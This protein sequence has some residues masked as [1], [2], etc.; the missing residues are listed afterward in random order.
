MNDRTQPDHA[1]IP[2]AEWQAQERALRAERLGLST[3][4]DDASV[5]AY[6]A[7]ARALRQPLPDPLPDDFA[8]H[9]AGMVQRSRAVSVDERVL[10][11][12]V[13]GLLFALGASVLILLGLD[14]GHWWQSLITALPTWALT[15]PWLLSLAACATLTGLFGLWPRQDRS[16]PYLSERF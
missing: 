1:D 14:G 5:H 12:L 13:R 15:N 11:W 8:Q 6:R 2:D 16:V 4:A 7:V 3:H 9:M 10:A